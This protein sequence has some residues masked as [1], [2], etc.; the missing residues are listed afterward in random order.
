[1]LHEM[2]LDKKN[3]DSQGWLEIF[4]ET[5]TIYQL[6]V[7]KDNKIRTVTL[8]NNDLRAGLKNVS[9]FSIPS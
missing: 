2:F 8:T 6:E 4:I 5:R 1:M 7:N 9:G 3:T